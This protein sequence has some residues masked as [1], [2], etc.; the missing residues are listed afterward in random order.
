MEPRMKSPVLT[1]PGTLEAILSLN[2][3]TEEAGVPRATLELV[4]M[5]VGQINGCAVCVDMHARAFKR[6]G[7][8]DARSW[9]LTVWREAPYYTEAERAALALAES[10]TRMCDRT[11]AV[12]DDVWK[13]ASR[14]FN[15]TQLAALVMAIGVANLFNRLNATTRQISGEWVEKYV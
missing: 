7:E 4:H 13:E 14:H 3:A 1:L 8:S 15:E 9:S 10:A 6:L 11:N 5:R 2:K 12:P